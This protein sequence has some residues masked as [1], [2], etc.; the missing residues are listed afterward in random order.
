MQDTYSDDIQ[1]DVHSMITNFHF[2]ES[3]LPKDTDQ[4]IVQMFREF[5]T[6]IK[7]ALQN[8]MKNTVDS[9][10]ETFKNYYGKVIKDASSF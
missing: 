2:K 4:E 7:F 8:K 6:H 5:L 10:A 3:F 9:K 1:Q